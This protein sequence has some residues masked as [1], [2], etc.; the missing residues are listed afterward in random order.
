[1]D[2]RKFWDATIKI[3]VAI[4]FKHKALNQCCFDVG[5]IW[6]TNIYLFKSAKA[7]WGLMKFE[8]WSPTSKIPAQNGCQKT[9]TQN[10]NQSVIIKITQHNSK[11]PPQKQL[12]LLLLEKSQFRSSYYRALPRTS[13]STVTLSESIPL[14]ATQVYLVES[15]TWALDM[16]RELSLVFMEIRPSCS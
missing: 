7:Q 10:S 1:M 8:D 9:H 2:S 14:V 16:C 13:S 11:S 3:T 12:L 15:R 4:L 6:Q 5:S